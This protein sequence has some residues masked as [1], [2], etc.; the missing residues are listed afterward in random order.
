LAL[1]DL[2]IDR[3][4]TKITSPNLRS[5][6]PKLRGVVMKVLFA[7]I[8]LVAAASSA[9]AQDTAVLQ[10]RLL[11]SLSGEPIAGATV[12]VEEL[13]RETVSADD[14]AFRFEKVPPGGYHVSVR[15]TG[16]SARRTEVTVAATPGPPV[17]VLVDPDLHFQEVAS[18][19]AEARSQF[20]A[21]QPTTVLAGQ[22]LTKQ[23]ESSLGATLENQPGIAVRSFGPSP[24]RP[25]VRGLDGDRVLILQDGQRT[26]DLSSQSGD[27]GVSLNPASA[28]TIEVVRG[29]ATLLYGANAIGGL[30]NVITNEIPTRP[31]DGASGNFTVDL[32][33]AAEEGGGAGS[34]QIGNGKF[35]VNVGGGGRRSNDFETPEGKVPNSQSRN[36]FATVGVGWTGERGYAG[37]S[38]GY[39]D[40]KYGI[41]VVEGGTLQLTPRRHALT[42]R[43]GAD[44]LNGMFDGFRATI[45]HRRY[46]HEELEGEEVGTLFTNDT[47][48][49]QLM[50]SHRA[51]GR[52]KGSIGGWVLDRAF[53]AIGAEA[54]SP[55]VDQNGFAAFAYEEVTWPHVT[56]QFGGRV[57]RTAYAPAGEAER[58]FSNGSV[59]GGILLRPAA[60][61]DRLTIAA[62]V[63]RAARAPA[64]EELFF[65]G[66]HHGNFAFEIGNPTLR[67]ERALG[68]DLSLRWRAPRASGEV[69]YFRN[70]IADFIF[71]REITHE[72]FEEREEEFVDRFGGRE[73]VG[74]EVHEAEE[75]EEEE[76]S[77]V[78]FVGA[79]ALLQ[80]I[81][82][83][84][85]FQITTGWA[86]EVGL[87]FVR[88]SLKAGEVPLPRIPPLKFRGG[89]RYQRNALQVGGQ[90]IAAV[91]QDRVSGA[92]TPT[93]GYT[94]LRLYTS[95]SF[96]AGGAVS[97]ITLRIDNA[98]NELY[99]NHLSLIKDIVPEIGRNVKVV[100][101]VRF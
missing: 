4:I 34:V 89:L 21:F 1:G 35:A 73:A 50:G 31:V 63:A 94:L 71:R 41:P 97:T 91:K 45:A 40:T 88:G 56:L 36:G 24:S 49:I 15:T 58:N 51:V 18:V 85:D 69:T 47:S 2:A 26:G 6:N 86:A 14:G 25:V 70:D 8:L 57:D 28:E 83:H 93:D 72:E 82:A 7:S 11:N 42:F 79:D 43:A 32:G 23:L 22:E 74:H 66:L 100:Y 37:G 29:P 87:D 98:T 90:V 30:V 99:R 92:A 20:D 39:D 55:A 10:G 75:G 101:G 67:S 3:E 61:D 16:Y 60:A 78:E 68:V 65:F 44:R 12:V 9:A 81:E 95:Y 84:S 33:T 52:L 64:L 76:V 38:W 19:S 80:G 53:D 27:H 54:L 13:R 5:L 48:E 17:D 62:S 96:E 59:S 46:K 77:F